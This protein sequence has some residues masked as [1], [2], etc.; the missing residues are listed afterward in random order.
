MLESIFGSSSD[1][2]SQDAMAQAKLPIGFRDNCANLL[3]PL[4]KVRDTTRCVVHGAKLMTNLVS[5]TDFT[6]ALQVRKRASQL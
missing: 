3:I 4:N 1:V 5:L 6:Y 2:P